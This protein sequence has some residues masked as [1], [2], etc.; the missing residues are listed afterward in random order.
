MPCR[1]G[2]TVVLSSCSEALRRQL[3]ERGY[4]V[5]ETLLDAFLRSGGSACCPTLRLDRVSHAAQVLCLT[6]CHLTFGLSRTRRFGPKVRGLLPTR[7]RAA[8]CKS[9][10]SISSPSDQHF[11][12]FKPGRHMPFPLPGTYYDREVAARSY[13]GHL[14]VWEEMDR[15]GYDGVGPERA[16]HRRRTV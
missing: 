12:E 9:S 6:C 5:V 3:N 14:A 7:V 4:A 11:D 2:R 1:V 10:C 15:L 16:S 8:S 13:E